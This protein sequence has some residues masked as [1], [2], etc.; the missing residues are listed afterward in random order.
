MAT[1]FDGMTAEARGQEADFVLYRGL[2]VHKVSIIRDYEGGPPSDLSSYTA[3][4]FKVYNSNGVIIISC[5]VINGKLTL[6]GVTGTIIID[7]T[8]VETSAL[9]LGTYAYHLRITS[10]SGTAQSFSGDIAIVD[11]APC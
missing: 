8:S 9:P 10:P 11:E 7:I 1:V 2:T 3:G 4:E 6:G 5:T